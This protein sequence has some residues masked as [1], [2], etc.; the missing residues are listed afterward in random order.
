MKYI[1]VQDMKSET[2]VSKNIF[3][4]DFFF[5]LVYGAVSVMLGSGVHSSLRIPYYIYSAVCAL[6][7]TMKSGWN[8][9]RRNWESLILFIR[10]DREI[11]YPVLNESRSTENGILR[12]KEAFCDE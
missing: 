10:K 3:L 8:K 2:K 5:L 4:F 12:R 6:F 9:K 7:L 11:Y 1:V